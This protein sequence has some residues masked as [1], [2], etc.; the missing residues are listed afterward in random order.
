MAHR[1]AKAQIEKI[2]QYATVSVASFTQKAA[3]AALASDTVPIRESYRRRRD[4]VYN[5]SLIH[6]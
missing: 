4:L 5:L 6:I 3:L 2:H 1:D